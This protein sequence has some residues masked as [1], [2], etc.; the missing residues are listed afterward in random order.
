MNIETL[1]IDRN[2]SSRIMRLRRPKHG[3]SNRKFGACCNVPYN[4][5]SFAVSN[6]LITL[7]HTVDGIDIVV[8]NSSLE[9]LLRPALSKLT[10]IEH[11]LNSRCPAVYAPR[12]H[13]NAQLN[14]R[15]MAT[16][17]IYQSILSSLDYLGLFAFY[18]S[19]LAHGGGRGHT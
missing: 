2:W 7:A 14:L 1:A 6:L 3:S 16:I 8:S 19:D 9:L 10:K 15:H 5:S 4:L 13:Q 11:R 12:S 18:R 17:P